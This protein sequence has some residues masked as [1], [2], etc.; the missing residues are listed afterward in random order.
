MRGV[1]GGDRG[2]Q[3]V[4][5]A[6]GARA[7]EGPFAGVV[8]NRPMDQ[9]YSYAI[10]RRL[11]PTM[12]VGQRVRVPLGRSNRPVTAYV[13]SIDPTAQVNPGKVKEVLEVLD[14]PPL[15]DGVMLELTRWM[16]GYYACS[17]GQALDAVVPAGVKKAAGTEVRTFL[18]VPDQIGR[19]HV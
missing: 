3:A 7:G 11:R 12:R 16:A 5:F 14:D 13:V 19:A 18:V 4:L 17:R 9:V 10:P 6:V 8:F 2:E 1:N 15:I